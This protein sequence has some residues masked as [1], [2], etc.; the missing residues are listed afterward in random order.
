MID[1]LEVARRELSPGPG[2]VSVFH[3]RRTQRSRNKW[4]TA[5][6]G[7]RVFRRWRARSR[8]RATDRQGNCGREGFGSFHGGWN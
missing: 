8:W 4:A 7:W 5:D 2:E 3:R 6:L 1:W